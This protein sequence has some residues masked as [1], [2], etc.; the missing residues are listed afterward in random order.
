M[1]LSKEAL[2]EIVAILQDGLLGAKDISQS[3]RELDL[4]EKVGALAIPSETEDVGKLTLSQEY[5]E[6][7]PRAPQWQ[8]N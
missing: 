6:K 7:H 4:V 2:L 3:L 1:R 5:T 8:E